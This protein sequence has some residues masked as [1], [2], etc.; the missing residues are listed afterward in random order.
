MV[1][2]LMDACGEYYDMLRVTGREWPVDFPF[3]DFID[4]RATNGDDNLPTSQDV[5]DRLSGKS[6]GDPYTRKFNELKTYREKQAEL[7]K[8]LSEGEQDESDPKMPKLN[9]PEVLIEQEKDDD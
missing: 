7:K 5:A 6:D 8:K 3:Q 1:D 2:D 4:T 9:E